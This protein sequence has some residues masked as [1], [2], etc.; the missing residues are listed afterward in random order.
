MAG[1]CYNCSERD[2]DLGLLGSR[3]GSQRP[4]LF[5]H[6]GPNAGYAEE[7]YKLYLLDPELVGSR[8][9]EYFASLDQSGSCAGAC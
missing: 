7:L 1:R 2:N 6:L 9:A 5:T 4:S 3:M 8:W